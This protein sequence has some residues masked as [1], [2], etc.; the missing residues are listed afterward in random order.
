MI[1]KQS[2]EN[3]AYPLASAP[4]L[5]DEP[6]V[7]GKSKPQRKDGELEEEYDD[8]E[9]LEEQIEQ[10]DEI[11]DV[12][13]DEEEM[14]EDQDVDQPDAKRRTSLDELTKTAPI[15]PYSSMFIFSPTSK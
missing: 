5:V 13:R 10:E 2:D 3:D 12:N 8:D 6:G 1:K 4:E 11:I 15:P 9:E 14:L 7:D